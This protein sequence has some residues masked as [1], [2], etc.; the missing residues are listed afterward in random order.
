MARYRVRTIGQHDD[1]I[2]AR[3]RA[4]FRELRGEADEA[5]REAQ[6]AVLPTVEWKGRTLHSI[7]RLSMCVSLRRLTHGF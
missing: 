4:C 3:T 2:A 7:P 1:A 6:I 5:V